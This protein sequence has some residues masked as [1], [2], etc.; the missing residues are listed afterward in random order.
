MSALKGVKQN[1]QKSIVNYLLLIIL[2]GKFLLHRSLWVHCCDQGRR[3]L[4]L[5]SQAGRIYFVFYVAQ[6]DLIDRLRITKQ[7]YKEINLC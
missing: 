7:V 4:Y 5:K 6:M 1:K 3:T 2:I